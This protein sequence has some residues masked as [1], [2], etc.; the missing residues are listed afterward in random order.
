MLA[1]FWSISC[2]PFWQSILRI[3]MISISINGEASAVF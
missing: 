2:N 1:P 3:E